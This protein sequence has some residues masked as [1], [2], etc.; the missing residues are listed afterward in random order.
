MSLEIQNEC[1]TTWNMV[2][3]CLLISDPGYL[4]HFTQG[5]EYHGKSL[6][7]VKAELERAQAGLDPLIRYVGL[8]CMLIFRFVI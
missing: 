7:E 8:V 4:R 6:M 5:R 3:I 1:N 2:C